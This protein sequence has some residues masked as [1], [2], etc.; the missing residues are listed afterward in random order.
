MA[1]RGR[2]RLYIGLSLAF[3]M[4]VMGPA[5][6]ALASANVRLVNARGGS[7]V[8]LQVSVN[9]QK[10]PAG[11][12]VAYAQV[13]ALASVPA[14][15]AQLSVGGKSVTKQLSD[16]K[17]YTVIAMPKNSIQVLRNGSATGKQ[18]RVRLVHAAPE[19]GMPDVKLG[20]K[21]IAQGVKFRSVSG[22]LTV[23]PGSYTLAITKP[24]GGATVFHMRIALA[25]GTASTVVVAGSA[26]NPER[27]VM[28]N[29]DTVTPAGAP[30]T[31][32]GGLAKAGTASW[33]YALL[34]ALIAGSLGG[35][36]A[37]FA[38]TRRSRS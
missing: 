13:G 21:T 16:G 14:G 2:N 34:A 36:A 37:Q 22:Y 32:F 6:A 11:S 4:L 27:L 38:R 31:G 7:P 10:T 20:Q 29:D 17:S 33:L 19:L 23:D 3:L 30:H 28:V 1:L 5:A 35:G 24:N 26:G 18:A 15:N 8:S 12:A 25:A 9:G